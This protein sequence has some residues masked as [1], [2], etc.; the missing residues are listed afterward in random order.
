MEGPSGIGKTTA[1]ERAL[2][3]TKLAGKLTKLSAR[4]PE[5][6]E[7]IEA[8]P[9]MGSRLGTVI[10]DDFHKLSPETQS[11]LADYLKTI[12]DREEGDIKLI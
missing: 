12:A 3:E 4:R 8:L 11:R 6:V 9:E 1:V 7:Y 5:D 10:V 2:E